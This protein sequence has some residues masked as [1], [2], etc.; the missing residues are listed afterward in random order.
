MHTYTLAT[1]IYYYLNP[2]KHHFFF[3]HFSCLFEKIYF[4]VTAFM[5]R[6]NLEFPQYF[7]TNKNYCENC[8][9][10]DNINEKFKI[11]KTAKKNIL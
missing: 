3:K 1:V 2:K 7:K 9:T 11:H 10:Y 8:V 6:N 4:F 5:V